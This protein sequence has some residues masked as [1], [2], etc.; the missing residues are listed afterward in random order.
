MSDAVLGGN[1]VLR[2]KHVSQ[3]T[4]CMNLSL[5]DNR[6][7]FHDA[8]LRLEGNTDEAVVQVQISPVLVRPDRI[9]RVVGGAGLFHYAEDAAKTVDHEIVG[10]LVPNDRKQRMGDT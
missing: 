2:A 1:L 8:R 7:R 9:P 5:A 4:A 10:P 3:N 6:D